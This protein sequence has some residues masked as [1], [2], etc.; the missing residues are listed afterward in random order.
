M[1]PPSELD[2]LLAMDAEQRSVRVPTGSAGRSAAILGAYLLGTAV[3]GIGG[4]PFLSGGSLDGWFGV[5]VSLFFAPLLHALGLVF[6]LAGGTRWFT[7]SAWFALVP[8][9][10]G[11]LAVLSWSRFA[12]IGRLRDL[13]WFA[14]WIA[15]YSVPLSWL[16]VIPFMT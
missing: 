13:G 5:L 10:A 14:L 6:L 1:M 15:I 3:G 2:R 16:F 11:V 12:R 9:A 7:G 4:L 8:L